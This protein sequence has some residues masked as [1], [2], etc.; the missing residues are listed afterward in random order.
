MPLEI[1]GPYSPP[2]TTWDVY[3]DG[4]ALPGYIE[5]HPR[6]G[7]YRVNLSGGVEGPWLSVATLEEAA[8]ALADFHV[9]NPP[10]P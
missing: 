4:R 1:R 5:F 6:T 7:H 2:G 9:G 10:P 8:Q 3:V